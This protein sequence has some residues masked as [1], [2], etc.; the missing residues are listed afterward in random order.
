MGFKH[1]TKQRTKTIQGL[2]SF[3]DTLPKKI[4]RILDKKGHI[5]TETLDNW[6]YIVGSK[7]FEVCYPKSFKNSNKLRDS[8]LNIMVKRGNEIDVEYS[9][10]SIIDKMNGFFGYNM[11]T[12]VKLITFEEEQEKFKKNKS[13]SVTKSEYIN[14]ISTIKND[15]IKN[16]LIE[17]SKLY[18]K[19]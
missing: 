10:K 14:K 1:N 9:K 19:K 5:Y 3:K 17:L 4:K 12:K 6:R 16:S 8:C 7:L 18:K 13:T 15:K 11:V 2:K